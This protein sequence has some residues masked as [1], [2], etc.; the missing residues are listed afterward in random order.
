MRSRWT[1][2]GEPVRGELN[3]ELSAL[4]PWS[5]AQQQEAL[6]SQRG[7]Q[8]T[9]DAERARRQEL[10]LQGILYY[11]T[12]TGA[13]L[14]AQVPVSTYQSWIRSNPLF[15]SWV[16]EARKA[17]A[18]AVESRLYLEGATAANTN[19]F[20]FLQARNNDVYQY[21]GDNH[22][23]TGQPIQ[24]VIVNK[25]PDGTTQQAEGA[26]FAPRI[27]EALPEPVNAQE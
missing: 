7:I 10:F 12:L 1:I 18:D 27:I 24:V 23:F 17:A 5:A 9:R 13:A 25:L 22:G 8:T 2:F 11:F 6:E 21:K 4:F 19:A 20:V 15:K 16:D 14:H 3:P 26:L